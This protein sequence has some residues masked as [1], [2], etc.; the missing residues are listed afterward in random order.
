MIEEVPS[1]ALFGVIHAPLCYVMGK[2]L[3]NSTSSTVRAA[4]LWA[5]QLHTEEHSTAG[6]S[7]H[8]PPRSLMRMTKLRG[9]L[10]KWGRSLVSFTLLLHGDGLHGNKVHFTRTGCSLG[11]VACALGQHK[12][13]M[14]HHSR[15][16]ILTFF[17]SVS[18]YAFFQWNCRSLLVNLIQQIIGFPVSKGACSVP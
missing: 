11:L 14:L 1:L 17:C 9:Q 2:R 13:D 4:A 6:F 10:K 8:C 12:M 16:L 18:L 7:F 3:S 15:S 5:T